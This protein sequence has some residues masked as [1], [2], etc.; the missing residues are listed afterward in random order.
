[1]VI[2]VPLLKI[3]A[4]LKLLN[5]KKLQTQKILLQLLIQAVIPVVVLI[6]VQKA[7]QKATQAAAQAAAQKALLLGSLKLRKM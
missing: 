7:A 3:V 1:M 5:L 2:A 6:V 4:I